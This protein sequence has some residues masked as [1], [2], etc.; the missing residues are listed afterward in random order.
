MS[1]KILDKM[2]RKQL[3]YIER[4]RYNQ[5]NYFLKRKIPL[6]PKTVNWF[7]YFR[8]LNIIDSRYVVRRKTVF[9]R[10]RFYKTP[11]IKI[12]RFKIN[13]PKPLKSIS[14]NMNARKHPK[15]PR[16][17][18]RPSMHCRY[19]RLQAS[20]FR[21]FMI[22]YVYPDPS[23][24]FKPKNLLEYSVMYPFMFIILHGSLFLL[25][26]GFVLTHLKNFLIRFFKYFLYLNVWILI[27]GL[28]LFLLLIFFF[29]FIYT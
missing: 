21:F 4:A 26:V 3:M 2:R 5:K 14:S 10:S 25:I 11:L 9:V 27:Y 19:H 18:I 8:R 24:Y 13:H 23:K 20:S 16:V 1:M 28:L 15:W 6:S 29:F 12:L 17:T 22:A 7:V